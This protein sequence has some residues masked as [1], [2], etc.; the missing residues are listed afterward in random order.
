[1]TTWQD[2]LAEKTSAHHSVVGTLQVARAVYSPQLDNTRDL[3]VYLPPSYGVTNRRYPVLYFH[4]GQNLFDQALSYV[5]EWQ[6]DETMEAL[7]ESDGIEAIVVGLPNTGEHRIAEYSP[8]ETRWG[9]GKGDLYLQFITK[10]VKPLIDRS[11]R[12]LPDRLNT[13]IGGSSMGGLISLYGYFRQ[14]SVFGM[15]MVMSPSLWLAGIK[16]YDSIREFP[17]TP[18]RLY[19]DAG[20]NEVKSSRYRAAYLEGVQRMIEILK[21][22]GYVEGESLHYVEDPKGVHH[23]SAWARRLPEALRFL[24]GPIPQPLR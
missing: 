21:H 11:F 9:G 6:V 17:Y 23:E 8:F 13:G 19:L 10:T 15:G 14:G 12:T 18:G 20:N 16:I 4:D 5:E 2:Y 3:Y 7:A 1:M 24:L 22:K